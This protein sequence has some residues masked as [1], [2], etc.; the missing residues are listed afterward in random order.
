LG[1]WLKPGSER[2]GFD[3][4]QSDSKQSLTN[5]AWNS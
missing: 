1:E 5:N 3:S 4:A 2:V